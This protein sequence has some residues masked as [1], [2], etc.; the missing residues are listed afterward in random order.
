[1]ARFREDH[2]LLISWAVDCAKRVLYLFQLARCD[3]RPAQA[4]RVARQWAYGEVA[5]G[6]AM[7]A[8]VA[9]HTAS[10]SVDNDPVGSNVAVAVARAAGYAVAT[11][12]FADHCLGGSSYALKS[13]VANGCDPQIELGWQSSKIPG[14]LRDIVLN[15]LR[16]RLSA[17][18][19]DAK[20]P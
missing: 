9:A 11:A 4:I 15:G 3:D 10:R 12:H 19:I 7:K 13:I 2:V 8:S 18:G 5:T 6:V 17:M 1:M 14:G 16:I 20:I